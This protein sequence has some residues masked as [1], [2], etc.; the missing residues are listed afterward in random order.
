MIEPGVTF[1]ALHEELRSRGSRL[2]ISPTGGPPQGSVL[3]NAIDRG[4]GSGGIYSDHFGALCGIEI[5][6]G[7]GNLV[8]TG[9]GSLKTTASNWH[10]SKYSFGPGLDGLFSQSNYGIVTQ[11]GVWLA[12]RPPAIEPFV[13]T[14]PDDDDLGSLIDLVRQLKMSNFVPTQI[15][16][17]S[18]L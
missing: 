2:M 5:V 16:I 11:A 6:L 17:I 1:Q 4:G 9:D 3:G 7:N 14:F 13:L 10:L 12:L 18:D 15:R 8:R